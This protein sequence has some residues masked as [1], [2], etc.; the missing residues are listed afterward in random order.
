MHFATTKGK[1]FIA[2]LLRE[3]DFMETRELEAEQSFGVKVIGI[4]ASF[5][6]IALLTSSIIAKQTSFTDRKEAS[7]SFKNSFLHHHIYSFSSF[8]FLLGTHT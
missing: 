4:L 8:L 5:I 6:V 1:D 2:E 7:N 3:Q